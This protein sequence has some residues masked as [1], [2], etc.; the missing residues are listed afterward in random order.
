MWFWPCVD[1]RIYRNKPATLQVLDH[2]K[3]I[4]TQL[5]LVIIGI[6]MLLKGAVPSR[7]IRTM[8]WIKVKARHYK[9]NRRKLKFTT[10]QIIITVRLIDLGKTQKLSITTRCFFSIYCDILFIQM[11]F[12]RHWHKSSGQIVLRCYSTEVSFG[13]DFR[14]L[15]NLI[16]SLDI[17][18]AVNRE[19]SFKR[20]SWLYL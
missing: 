3:I 8:K 20:T 4:T 5:T 9:I 17:K 16:R 13:F 15:V 10:K 11:K 12:I 19:R 18:L 6:E 2:V 14:R 7:E 1:F